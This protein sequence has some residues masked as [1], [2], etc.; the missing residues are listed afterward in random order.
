L[1]KYFLL[2]KKLSLL[3]GSVAPLPMV[4]IGQILRF[5]ATSFGF[6]IPNASSTNGQSANAS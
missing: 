5:K 1:V 3:L 4:F 6:L 2:K